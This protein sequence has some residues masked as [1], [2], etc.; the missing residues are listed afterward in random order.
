[1]KKIL[2]LG[3]AQSSLGTCALLMGSY[4]KS[5]EKKIYKHSFEQNLHLVEIK[6]ILRVKF[7][8]TFR[9]IIY[10]SLYHLHKDFFFFSSGN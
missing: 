10:L 8:A 5:N 7:E 3:L 9:L 2:F 6:E 1:M 4:Y